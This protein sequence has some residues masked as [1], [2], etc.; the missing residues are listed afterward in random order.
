MVPCHFI[1]GGAGA[2][3]QPLLYARTHEWGV[4]PLHA[5]DTL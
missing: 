3:P 2:T 4:T 1:N 5:V